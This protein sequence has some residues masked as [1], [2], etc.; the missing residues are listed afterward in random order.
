MRLEQ[1]LALASLSQ[2][3]SNEAAKL[4]IQAQASQ[5]L[6]DFNAAQA[7]AKRQR[8]AEELSNEAAYYNLLAGRSQT[9]QLAATEIY[10]PQRIAAVRGEQDARLV[11]VWPLVAGS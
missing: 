5:Q 4:R 10:K 6:A 9:E 1:E 3:A 8:Q 7:D 2:R 11:L